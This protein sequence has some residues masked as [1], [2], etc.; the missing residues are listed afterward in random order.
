MDVK[1]HFYFNRVKILGKMFDF[2]SAVLDYFSIFS[3]ACFFVFFF[4][5]FEH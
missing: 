1:A 2:S 5:L 4:F 3:F